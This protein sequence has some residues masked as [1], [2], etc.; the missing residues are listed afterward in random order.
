MTA[1][2]SS[3]LP[4]ALVLYRCRM[5]V[6]HHAG[7]LAGVTAAYEELVTY[8]NDLETEP[9]PATSALFHDLVRPAGRR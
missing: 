5:R 6:E 7:N 3:R 9:S 4:I 8:L 2:P 1:R